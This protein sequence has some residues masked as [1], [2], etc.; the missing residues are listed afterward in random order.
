MGHHYA[1]H[2]S[3]KNKDTVLP[4]QTCHLVTFIDSKEAG[5]SIMILKHMN[6]SLSLEIY[7]AI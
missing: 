7:N 5:V 1:S 3:H 4:L 6:L 2:W